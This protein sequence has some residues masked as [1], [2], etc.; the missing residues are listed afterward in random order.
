MKIGLLIIA[1]NKYTQFAQNLI[2][3]ADKWFLPSRNVTY[4]IFSNK[5]LNLNSNRKIV[6]SYVEHKPWPWMTLGRYHIFLN[7]KNLFNDI[8][9]LFYCDVD[10]LFSG[11]VGEEIISESVVTQH[12]LYA[13][14]RGTPETRVESTAHVPSNVPMQYF[15]GGFNGG[16]KSNFLKMAQKISE[17]IDKDYSNG[18]I[19]IWH[20]ESHL[21]KYYSENVPSKILDPSYCFPEEFL[22]LFNPRL[23]ALKKNHEE[24]RSL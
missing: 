18:L 19:A 7:N 10:M 5:E 11:P 13:G 1:T 20:D 12:P 22:H 6:N 15:A 8:D 17:N 4:F 21:N 14:T 23:I 9:Y 24:I 2:S 3:S 16:S